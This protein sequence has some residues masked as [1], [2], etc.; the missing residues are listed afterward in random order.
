MS[1]EY[2]ELYPHFLYI[3]REEKGNTKDTKDAKEDTSEVKGITVKE[4]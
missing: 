4:V 2:H 1:H 3:S